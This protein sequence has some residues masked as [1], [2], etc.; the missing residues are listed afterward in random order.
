MPAVSVEDRQGEVSGHVCPIVGWR[1]ES[2][3]EVS[4]C[5]WH[6]PIYSKNCAYNDEIDEAYV[7]KIKGLNLKETRRK[8]N[9][10]RRRIEEIILLD[11]YL[12]FVDT[13][14]GFSSAP[15]QD[16]NLDKLMKSYPFS[17]MQYSRET[18]RRALDTEL[19]SEYRTR[20]NLPAKITLEKLLPKG[21]LK[22][23]GEKNG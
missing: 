4:T 2:E 8:H 12:S 6:S 7:A 14:I 13:L 16:S 10:A 5:M 11:D 1:I 15:E 3:C 9:T 19:F 22:P 18:V 17:E 21:G 20:R 23:K